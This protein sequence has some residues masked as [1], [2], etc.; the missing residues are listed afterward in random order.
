[1]KVYVGGCSRMAMALLKRHRDEDED[2][3]ILLIDT[4][5]R[6]RKQLLFIKDNQFLYYEMDFSVLT[7]NEIDSFYNYLSKLNKEVTEVITMSGIN[8]S[9]NIFS[10]T[11]DE[12]EKTHNINVTGPIFIVK[13]VVNFMVK[14]SKII[15][16]SSIN[17]FYGHADRIDYSAA[18]SA[19]NQLCRNLAL[20]LKD[21]E[22]TVNGLLPGYIIDDLNEIPIDI[23]YARNNKKEV[24]NYLLDYEEVTDV[25]QFLTSPQSNAINGQLIVLDKGY[26]L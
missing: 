13:A 21:H 2:E 10:V 11:L 22:I 7:Q 16:V 25:L 4:P 6:I 19:L 9:N 26:T 17:S 12:W 3:E 18:K 1:M 24:S 14:R 23:V 15:L 20:E 5:Q 8:Y